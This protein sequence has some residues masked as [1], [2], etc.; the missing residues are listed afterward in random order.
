MVLTSANSVEL[1]VITSG[2]PL[3]ERTKALLNFNSVSSDS[4]IITRFRNPHLHHVPLSLNKDTD[5]LVNSVLTTHYIYTASIASGHISSIYFTI[6]G[7][8]I[9]SSFWVSS[10]GDKRQEKLYKILRHCSTSLETVEASNGG[11][12]HSWPGRCFLGEG[13]STAIC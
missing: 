11:F 13:I 3:K 6:S 12:L 4:Y 1:L 9:S 7:H 8:Y 5:S 2:S 10:N